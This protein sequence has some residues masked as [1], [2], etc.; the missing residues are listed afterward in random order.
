[1]EKRTCLCCGYRTLNEEPPGAD[2]CPI[3]FWQVSTSEP[4][5]SGIGA[6][7]T[8]LREAQKNF[9]KFGAC[10]KSVLPFVRKP[11]KTDVKDPNWA[12]FA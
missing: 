2:I 10:D 7:R 3:C 5:D 8:T 4:D 9:I 1:M 6:N 11:T 12:A